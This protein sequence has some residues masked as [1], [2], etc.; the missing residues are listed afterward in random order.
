MIYLEAE[1]ERQGEELGGGGGGGGG[2][3]EMAF[4]ATCQLLN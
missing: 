2:E 4:Y 3:R 1:R